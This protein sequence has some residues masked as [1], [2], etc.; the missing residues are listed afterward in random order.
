MNLKTN[1]TKLN[2]FL[3]FPNIPNKNAIRKRAIYVFLL[4]NDIGLCF[5]KFFSLLVQLFGTFM[6]YFEYVEQFVNWFG[7]VKTK[8]Q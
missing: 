4:V 1:S 5:G 3:V 2:I 8:H 6:M 7:C